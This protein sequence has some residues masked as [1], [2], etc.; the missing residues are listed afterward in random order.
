MWKQI[1]WKGT[2]IHRIDTVNWIKWRCCY[3][4][5]V[6]CSILF[7]NL[8]LVIAYSAICTE[9]QWDQNNT[10]SVTSDCFCLLLLGLFIISLYTVAVSSSW[11]VPGCHNQYYP[12]LWKE[13]DTPLLVTEERA[14]LCHKEHKC[15]SQVFESTT[16]RM[17]VW[18]STKSGIWTISVTNKCHV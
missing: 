13:M 11:H 4:F 16:F 2:C 8:L 18:Q 5:W 9:G 1:W 14:L 10:C 6:S 3:H 15:P 17:V 7:Q 12:L